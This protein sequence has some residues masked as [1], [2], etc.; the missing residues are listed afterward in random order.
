M[1]CGVAVGFGVGVEVRVGVAVRVGAAVCVCAFAITAVAVI[2]SLEGA[3]P[4][5][6]A[7]RSGRK[8]ILHRKVVF[9]LIFDSPWRATLTAG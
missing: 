8:S 3:Q 6:K 1:G 4:A 5:S 2:C 7:T 9:E